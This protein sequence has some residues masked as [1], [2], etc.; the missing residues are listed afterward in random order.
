[1]NT[2]AGSGAMETL[3]LDD[4]TS[5]RL[6]LSSIRYN[7]P[8]SEHG[9]SFYDYAG[10][11]TAKINLGTILIFFVV[12]QRLKIYLF[13]FLHARTHART[14]VLVASHKT[15]ARLPRHS[16]RTMSR[17]QIVIK[18]NIKLIAPHT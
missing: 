5:I 3:S 18:T 6:V 11:Y 14:H 7:S 4:T 12:I 8:N 1:M 15:L 10:K 13:Y 9:V 2:L 17:N 16:K